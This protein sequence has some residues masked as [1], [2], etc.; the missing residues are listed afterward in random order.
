M[1]QAHK[2]YMLELYVESRLEDF[3]LFFKRLREDQYVPRPRSYDFSL[4]HSTPAGY[5][6]RRRNDGGGNWS[7]GV[8]GSNRSNNGD[9]DWNEGPPNTHYIGLIFL[10]CICIATA[11]FLYIYD[12]Q[13]VGEGTNQWIHKFLN[14]KKPLE[15]EQQ[16]P[17][18]VRLPS[19]IPTL[20]SGLVLG[21][22][23]Y[24]LSPQYLRAI[25]AR[26][27]A[28]AIVLDREIGRLLFQLIPPQLHAMAQQ[29]ADWFELVG[30]PIYY[31]INP[32]FIPAVL[33]VRAFT[34]F[35]IKIYFVLKCMAL[36]VELYGWI[37]NKIPTSFVTQAR[38]M[39]QS[40][41]GSSTSVEFFLMNFSK[42]LC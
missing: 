29:L 15:D 20:A 26:C 19:L 14:S 9:D 41:S 6:I 5:S 27:E 16:Y 11:R 40:L 28:I 22:L 2:Q 1:A 39:V 35:A 24:V 30:A 25:M 13:L 17:P 8:G 31:F 37:S 10:G 18:K 3:D 12:S 42:C 4:L 32:I 23:S 21:I 38:D 36:G 34:L 33:F 7:N